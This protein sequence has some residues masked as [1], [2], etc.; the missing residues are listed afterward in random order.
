[1]TPPCAARPTLASMAPATCTAVPSTTINTLSSANYAPAAQYAYCVT[2][3]DAT[4]GEE[5]VASNIAYITNSD[6]IALV[7]GSHII[8]WNPVANAAYYN[9]EI[10][11]LKWQSQGESPEPFPKLEVA[12][13]NTVI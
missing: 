11:F 1:M 5:S 6:D 8:T 12:S 13:S 3:V 10:K 2:A 9:K 7:A 4:T